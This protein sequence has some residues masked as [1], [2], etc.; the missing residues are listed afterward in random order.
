LLE[1][2][3]KEKKQCTDEC[4]HMYANRM[5]VCSWNKEPKEQQKCKCTS[6]RK[7]LM[8][9]VVETKQC[10]QNSLLLN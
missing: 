3:G 6:N 5:I 2:N 4:N 1:K 9:T 10:K 8:V 7:Q